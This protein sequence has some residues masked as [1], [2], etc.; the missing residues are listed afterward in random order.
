MPG[1]E[2]PQS[3]KLNSIYEEGYLEKYGGEIGIARKRAEDYMHRVSKIQKNRR[4]LEKEAKK[5]LGMGQLYK[6]SK[7][8]MSDLKW[9]SLI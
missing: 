8:L 1:F 9:V 7:L 6:V 4:R 5:I 3:I 2:F